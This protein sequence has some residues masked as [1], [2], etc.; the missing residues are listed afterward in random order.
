MQA[1]LNE[2]GGGLPTV[3]ELSLDKP[4]SSV[5]SGLL[6]AFTSNKGEPPPQDRQ[7]FF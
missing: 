4:K 5:F 2:P 1:S 7:C 3:S 6:S